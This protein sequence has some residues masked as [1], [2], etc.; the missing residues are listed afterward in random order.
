MANAAVNYL[1]TGFMSEHFDLM[2]CFIL[3][4]G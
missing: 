3:N 2:N 1:C 4:A